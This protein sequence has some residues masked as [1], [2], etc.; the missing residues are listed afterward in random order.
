MYA[1]GHDP[2]DPLLTPIFADYSRGFCPT[3]ITSGTRDL[4]LSCAVMLHRAMRK[5]GV[6]AEL[7]VWEAMTHAPFFG[8][9]EEAELLA[10][11]FRFVDEHLG[12]A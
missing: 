8:A 6:K 9:P 2:R 4:L 3:I 12:T 1:R 7:H 11:Q 5:G 10:E